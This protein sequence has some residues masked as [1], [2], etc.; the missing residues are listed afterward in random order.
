MSK[1]IFKVY[2]SFEGIKRLIVIVDII[3]ESIVINFMRFGSIEVIWGNFSIVGFKL[4]LRLIFL[5]LFKEEGFVK[6]IIK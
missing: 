4:I 2:K 3:V 5:L 1:S 6:E